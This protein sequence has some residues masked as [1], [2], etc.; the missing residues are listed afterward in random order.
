MCGEEIS[1]TKEICP[2]CGEATHP[3]ATAE[4]YREQEEDQ[5]KPSKELLTRTFNA[6]IIGLF[7][8]PG[9]LHLYAVTLLIRY[10]RALRSEGD[11]PVAMRFWVSLFISLGV[12]AVVLRLAL[13]FFG[14]I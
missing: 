14:Y 8:L 3:H 11:E 7:T 10:Y 9:L 2:N 13:G 4:D 1:T 5:E 6:T 12:I